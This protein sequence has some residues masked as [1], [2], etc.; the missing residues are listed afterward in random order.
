MKLLK[1]KIGIDSFHGTNVLNTEKRN[2][3]DRQ[4]FVI[5]IRETF[6]KINDIPRREHLVRFERGKNKK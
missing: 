3:A 1:I 5:V 4:R 6:L 2:N